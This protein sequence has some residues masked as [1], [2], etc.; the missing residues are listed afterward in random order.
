VYIRIHRPRDG[1][2]DYLGHFQHGKQVLLRVVSHARDSICA[3]PQTHTLVTH[4]KSSLAK[5]TQLALSKVETGRRR[6]SWK[7]SIL[8]LEPGAYF[9]VNP[10][11]PAT[12]KKTRRYPKRRWI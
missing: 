7:P 2:V 9:L 4:T 6:G 3:V 11:K 5:L 10:V 1:P 8:S 12:T